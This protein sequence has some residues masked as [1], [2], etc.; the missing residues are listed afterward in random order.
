MK[1]LVQFVKKDTKVDVFIQS[2]EVICP[3]CKEPCLLETKNY[4]IKLFNCK[5]NHT[6]LIKIKDF[7]SKQ[8][9]NIY[10]KYYVKFAHLKIWVIVL[11]MNFINV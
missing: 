6:N 7:P 8:K 2:N 11:T 10:Q 4:K 9:I 1:V 3:D 5:N